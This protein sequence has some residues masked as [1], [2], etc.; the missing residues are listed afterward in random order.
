MHKL[1]YL[2]IFIPTLLFAQDFPFQQEYDTI[3]V[4][5]EGWNPSVPWQKGFSYS[6]PAFGDMDLDGDLDLAIGTFSKYLF[7]YLN[8]GDSTSPQ[9]S[10]LDPDFILL[11]TLDAKVNPVFCD[12]NGDG[13]SDLIY[14]DGTGVVRYYEN[15]SV[16]GQIQ[17]VLAGDSINGTVWMNRITLVDIDGDSDFDLISGNYDGKLTFLRNDGSNTQYSFTFV[18][19]EFEGIDIGIISNPTFCDID[20]D[21][22]FDLFIGDKD[23]YIWFFENIGSATNYEF[24][25]PV[26]NY[27]NYDVGYHASPEFCDIDRDDDLD[28]FVGLE[29]TF[30][31]QH[32]GDVFFFEN[33]GTPQASSYEYIT[34]N[35]LTIDIGTHGRQQFI[36]IDADNDLDLFVGASDEIRFFK[37]IGSPQ[38][39]NFYLEE[40]YYQGISLESIVPYFADI[41]AD[42]D[43]DLFAGMGAIPGPPGL[44]LYINRG[45]PQQAEYFLYSDN[46]VPG[47]YFVMVAPTLVDIDYDGDYDLFVTD[48]WYDNIWY[49][50][51]IGSPAWPVFAEPILNWQGISWQSALQRYLR[52]HDIDAD[53]DLDLFFYNNW[54][55]PDGRNLRF[56]ENIGTANNPI[57]QFRTN[58]YLPISV[59]VPCPWFCDIDSD[60]FIDLFT[61]DNWGG[62][63]FFHGIDTLSVTQPRL[64]LD[65]FHG[66]Q[67]SIGPNPANPIT[68][69]SYNLPY[70]QKAEIAVYNLLGQKVATLAEGLQMP[71]QKTL[72]WDAANYSS[73]QYFIRMETEMGVTSDRVVVVK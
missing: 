2:I 49:F 38:M 9:F 8:T 68:W 1:F 61:A 48:Q 70:P 53:G 67:F 42:G 27:L 33:R 43:F 46:F 29:S 73:G 16:G 44:H 60:G 14:S 56:F 32:M 22:D 4:E 66:I 10:W 11:D 28:L 30:S 21:G 40:E 5:I 7:F 6:S 45:T 58:T 23:G 69:I 35:Y 65:P 34:S 17:Y 47:N 20:A 52:F 63:L 26:F 15:E 13:D 31:N 39:P 19:D 25:A 18:T 57:M 24:A 55:E 36:D 59:S 72:I 51:N 50:E 54:N 62:I 3:P 64:T 71:G 37:N 41:D 12:L